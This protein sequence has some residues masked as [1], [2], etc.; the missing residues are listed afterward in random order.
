MRGEAKIAIVGP[1]VTRRSILGTSLAVAGSLLI[2][3]ST[4]ALAEGAGPTLDAR[5]NVGAVT[6][7]T[8]WVRIA[9]DNSITLICSQSEMGQGISTTLTAAL[10]D[11][12]GVDWRSAKIEFAPFA[13]AYRNPVIGW[14]FTGASISTQHFYMLVRQMGASAR[15]MLVSAAAAR[16][17]VP[18]NQLAIDDGIIRHAASA[19]QVSF[20]EVAADAAKLQL[21]KTPRLKEDRDLRYIGK[22]LPRWDIPSKT[23]GSAV[24]G[25][26]VKVPGMLLAAVRC[27]PGIGGRLDSYDAAS[28]KAKP[29]VVAVVEVPRGLAVVAKTYWQARR[30]LDEANLVWAD[31]DAGLTSAVLAAGYREKFATGPFVPKKATGD[32]AAAL[33]ASAQKLDAE[34]EVPFQ[35]HATMEPMNCTAHV[36]AEGCDLWIPTQMVETIAGIA[37]AITGLPD[38]RIRIHRTLIGGG[39]GRRLH[40]DDG[41]QALIIAKAVQRPVKLIWSR[42]EDMT[43]DFYR[44]AMLHRV[45]GGLD[46]QGRLAALAHR[47]VSP[48]FLLYAWP[49]GPENADWTEP[50]APP[51]DYD[52]MAVE[53]LLDSLYALP[54]LSVEQHYLDS[55]VPVS[56]WRTTGHGPNCFALESFIDELAAAAKTDP[57]TFRR[58][59]LAGNQR[60][61]KLLN[62]VAEKAGWDQ[63]L[64]AKHG[65][66]VAIAQA[67]GGLIAQVAEVSASD[68]GF[69]IHRIL[70]AVDCGKV[71]DPGIAASNIAGGVVWGLSGLRTEITIERGR[72]VQTNFDAFDPLHLWETPVIETHFVESG[73][74][75][76]GLGEI[77]PVPTHAA[78]CNA[79]FAAT[80]RRIRALPLAKSGVN[81]S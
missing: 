19:R 78:V 53:G 47:V 32:A 17:A 28:I 3:G 24:F 75:V 30:A 65:R 69:K 42:E 27:A 6:D 58:A 16:L 26:D 51:R 22:P 36:T 37:R 12:L 77:G 76:G 74:K 73:E 61:L 60:A 52:T 23:D 54:N 46:D 48:S 11:E 81:L 8:A 62:V 56:V 71:L 5:T 33:T 57:L 79:I 15:E 7:I 10:A 80:G 43:H 40:C 55:K 1:D 44:P 38:E 50:M 63:P 66:G 49:R 13:A 64:P 2:G 35:A 18:A 72:V 45:S 70:S 29:G 67:F 4:Q 25:I 68:N 9:P 20:G 14:M 59:H 41:K 21:P 39:F 34:Y 31:E